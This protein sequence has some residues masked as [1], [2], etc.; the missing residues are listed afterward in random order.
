LARIDGAKL[1]RFVDMREMLGRESVPR[2]G[3]SQLNEAG[4]T[5][6]KAPISCQTE[7]DTAFETHQD[8]EKGN[9]KAVMASE[10]RFKRWL[11]VVG[12]ADRGPLHGTL[13]ERIGTDSRTLLRPARYVNRDHLRHE[14]IGH[15]LASG[16]GF[17]H[18]K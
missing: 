15:T 12:E 1:G 3:I 4:G 11:R 5:V 6:E 7:A 14:G 17:S 13:D 2:P 16:V 10:F 8:A 18:W 9:L